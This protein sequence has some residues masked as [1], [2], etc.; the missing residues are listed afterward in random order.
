MNNSLGAAHGKTDALT[1]TLH[2]FL[3]S[4][5]QVE[6]DESFGAHEVSVVTEQTIPVLLA[7]A[8]RLSGPPVQ[9]PEPH[10]RQPMP[11]TPPLPLIVETWGN[12]TM[13]PEDPEDPEFPSIVPASDVTSS[14]RGKKKKKERN[15]KPE[16]KQSSCAANNG[17][18]TTEVVLS[19]TGASSFR[20]DGNNM[21]VAK[22]VSESLSSREDGNL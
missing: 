8:H 19:S 17:E 20:V 9:P 2:H 4:L 3:T 15:K 7:A 10:P 1:S 21:L 13:L 22:E 16:K 14:D 11:I 12:D 18:V 6:Q 5:Q